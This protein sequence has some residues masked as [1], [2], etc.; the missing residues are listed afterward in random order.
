VPGAARGKLEE[1]FLQVSRQDIEPCCFDSLK[2]FD[3]RTCC[4][5]VDKLLEADWATVRNKT[6]FFIGV[7]KRYR[8]AGGGEGGNSGGYHGALARGNDGGARMRAPVNREPSSKKAS[9]PTRSRKPPAKE[10]GNAKKGGYIY[11]A[12]C[13][14]AKKDAKP[15]DWACQ[16]GNVNFASRDT[17]NYCDRSSTKGYHYA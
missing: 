12:A 7:L 14:K 16:C 8:Q 5:I 6:G 10:G 13:K 9:S 11:S 1:L 3:E 4:E 2:D 15:G 17:C